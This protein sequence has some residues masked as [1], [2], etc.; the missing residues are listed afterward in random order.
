ML[1]AKKKIEK[2]DYHK[3]DKLSGSAIKLFAKDRWKFYR[4]FVLKEK[5]VENPSKSMI[6]GS[7]CDF[8]L[9]DCLGDSEIF[10]QRL[11]EKFKLSLLT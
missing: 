10:N 9:S 1:A 3:I 4:K 6:L 7:L 2:E 5:E 11:E 8:Y